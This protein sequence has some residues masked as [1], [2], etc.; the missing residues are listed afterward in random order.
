V[1]QAAPHRNRGPTAMLRRVPSVL[2]A[3]RQLHPEMSA[4]F[5][6]RPLGQRPPLPGPVSSVAEA[7]SRQAGA[8]G[9]PRAEHMA[10]LPIPGR[11]VCDSDIQ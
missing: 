4:L 5:G 6:G 7:P 1:F 8:G 3:P 11:G 2:G 10:L 9:T